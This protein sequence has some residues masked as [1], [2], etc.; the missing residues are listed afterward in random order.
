MRALLGGLAPV[1]SLCGCIEL[2][3]QAAP[4]RNDAAVESVAVPRDASASEAR[5]PTELSVLTWN[6]EWL[7]HAEEGPVD[8]EAQYLAVRDVL[9]SEQADLVALQELAS[10]PAFSRLLEDLPNR[11]GVLSGYDAPQ[12]TALLWDRARFLLSSTRPVSGL[13]DAG[14]PPL[15]VLLHDPANEHLLRIVVIHAKAQADTESHAR[16]ARLSD[17]LHEYLAVR[18][19]HRL[20]LGDFNDLLVGSIVPGAGTPYRAFTSDDHYVALTRSLN[21]PPARESSYAFGGTID[22]VV[23][24]ADDPLAT[25]AISINVLRD[26]LLARFPD[27]FDR[28]SDHFPVAVALRWR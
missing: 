4:E 5:E 10:E 6:V 24:G 11:S 21:E 16:R 13:D 15:E 22:H 25:E 3:V 8:D 1:L 7:G 14:R 9:R 2:P 12:R 19:E 18:E 28:V 17:G 20:V 27:Y 23:A 26:E